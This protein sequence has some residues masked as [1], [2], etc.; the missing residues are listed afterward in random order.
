M[1]AVRCSACSNKGLSSLLTVTVIHLTF[2]KPE[3][4]T[5]QLPHQA[6]S[7]LSISKFR[8]H[9]LSDSET[10]LTAMTSMPNTQQADN[11][12]VKRTCLPAKSMSVDILVPSSSSKRRRGKHV[13]LN[14]FIEMPLDILFEVCL[15]QKW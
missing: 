1:S 15:N 14:N 8:V 7:E 4:E 12:P 10:P 6:D 13:A 5:P 11:R 2:Y 9:L 3:F